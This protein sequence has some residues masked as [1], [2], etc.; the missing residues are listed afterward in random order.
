[1][2]AS[3]YPSTPRLNDAR[4]PE[5]YVAYFKSLDVDAIRFTNVSWSAPT[6]GV[7]EVLIVF[8]AVCAL[9]QSSK[10]AIQHVL[11]V[12]LRFRFS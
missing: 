3:I 8:F 11:E 10:V 7:L 6:P 2:E 9:V 1:M 4:H 5:S 12:L